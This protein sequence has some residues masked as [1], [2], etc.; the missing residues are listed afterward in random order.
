MSV[1][2]CHYR[3][4]LH[5]VRS[6][7]QIAAPTSTRKN[8]PWPR[9][10]FSCFVTSWSDRFPDFRSY[11]WSSARAYTR[12]HRHLPKS[13]S[14]WRPLPLFPVTPFYA[15][16]IHQTIISLPGTLL[17]RCPKYSTAF[18]RRAAYKTSPSRLIPDSASQTASMPPVP[19]IPPLRRSANRSPASETLRTHTSASS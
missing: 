15:D 10:S 19:H 11:Q 12:C 3:S 18:H 16:S 9:S 17:H 6:K 1:L 13:L 7:H 2:W 8:I 4:I 5:I 14:C